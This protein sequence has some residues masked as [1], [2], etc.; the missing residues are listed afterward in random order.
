MS[1][2]I[3]KESVLTHLK[4]SLGKDPE[5]ATN[6]DWRVALSHAVR[7]RIVD[8]WF[9]ATRSAYRADAKRVYY[10]SMEFL[11]AGWGVWP[12]VSL[13]AC[14]HLESRPMAM[15]SVTNMDCSASGS[16][17]TDRSRNPKTG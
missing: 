8:P 14:R 12:H 9:N 7:D 5:H 17:M 13:K 15:A 4:Y 6:Y 3:L 10:L 1:K 2:D 16:K 11:I